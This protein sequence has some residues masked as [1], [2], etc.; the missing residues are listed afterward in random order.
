MIRERKCPECG[1]AFK[2]RHG[3]QV[4]CTREC[5]RARNKRLDRENHVHI[6]AV[7]RCRRERK[8]EKRRRDAALA[9]RDAAYAR[10]YGHPS[11]RPRGQLTVPLTSLESV[12]CVS[13][14]LPPIARFATTKLAYRKSKPL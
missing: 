9:A 12:P 2:P 13:G 11:G 14:S 8:A 7:E 1:A 10:E 3:N 4:C 5:Q 6:S